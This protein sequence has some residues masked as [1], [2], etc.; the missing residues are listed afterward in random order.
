MKVMLS[1]DQTDDNDHLHL[2]QA[3]SAL[4]DMLTNAEEFTSS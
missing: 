3:T 1:K 2:N 4:E